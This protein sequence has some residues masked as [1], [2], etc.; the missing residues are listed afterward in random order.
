MYKNEFIKIRVYP[1]LDETK[2]LIHLDQLYSEWSNNNKIPYLYPNLKKMKHIPYKRSNNVFGY[3]NNKKLLSSFRM[4]V[5][6]IDEN[7][8]VKSIYKYLSSPKKYYRKIYLNRDKLFIDIDKIDRRNK[9]LLLT[10]NGVDFMLPFKDNRPVVKNIHSQDIKSVKITIKDNHSY[11]NAS[12]KE[13]AVLNRYQIYV[14]IGVTIYVDDKYDYD[15]ILSND[16][17]VGVDIGEDSLLSLSKP[18]LI[19]GEYRSKVRLPYFNKNM[20]YIRY[21]RD[22]SIKRYVI[23]SVYNKYRRYV[24]KIIKQIYE[25]VDVVYIEH[26]LKL[27]DQKF[28]TNTHLSAILSCVDYTQYQFKLKAEVFGKLCI[29]TPRNFASSH[30]CSKCGAYNTVGSVNVREWTCMC[31][32]THHDRDINAAINI[33]REGRNALEYLANTGR[34]AR[35]SERST[36]SYS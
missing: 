28:G 10:L 1:S 35:Y 36:G 13:E 26:D 7:L 21:E 2:R 25:Q 14:T 24:S 15:E 3:Y 31:C 9:L 8:N 5:D 6:W 34:R 19:N 4:P 32:R 16:K 23:N 20:Q 17:S 11:M 30:I 27:S 33:S 29:Q 12:S 22:R 18:L